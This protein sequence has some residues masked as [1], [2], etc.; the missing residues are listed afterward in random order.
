[1]HVKLITFHCYNFSIIK[2]FM[3]ILEITTYLFVL[4][5]I[6]SNGYDWRDYETTDKAAN[7]TYMSV[8]NIIIC[9][10]LLVYS[11]IYYNLY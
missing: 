6:G 1:M 11:S 4:Y 9:Y 7:G 5:F 2:C 3:E 8:S 10:L